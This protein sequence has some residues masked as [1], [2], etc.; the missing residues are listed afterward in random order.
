[1]VNKDSV[2][3]HAT[4]AQLTKEMET[5]EPFVI[6]VKSKTLT[7]EDFTSWSGDRADKADELLSALQGID[8]REVD[9]VARLWLS[10]QDFKKWQAAKLSIR[11]KAVVLRAAGQHILKD[12]QPGE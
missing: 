4:L 3:V 5:P 10:A 2:K 6:G 11:E 9:D 7:F 1:M 8:D 12:F